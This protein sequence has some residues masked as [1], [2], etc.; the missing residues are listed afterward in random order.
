MLTERPEPDR[1][2]P[3]GGKPDPGEPG[4]PIPERREPDQ[5]DPSRKDPD[6]SIDA[7]GSYRTHCFVIS[8][9][10]WASEAVASD[11]QDE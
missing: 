3:D 5:D 4:I 9:E 2:E 10:Q 6:H 1:R 7:D 11:Q 8:S